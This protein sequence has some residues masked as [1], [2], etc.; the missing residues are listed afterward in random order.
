MPGVKRHF[1]KSIRKSKETLPANYFFSS[2][3]C[4]RDRYGGFIVFF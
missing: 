4:C 3:R 2:P 1:E